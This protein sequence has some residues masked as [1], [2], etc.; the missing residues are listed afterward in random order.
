MAT[1]IGLAMFNSSTRMISVCTSRNKK[2]KCEDS[3]RILFDVRGGDIVLIK[4]DSTGKIING[5]P[6]MTDDR[7][8]I[9]LQHKF[10]SFKILK[11]IPNIWKII[12]KSSK[13]IKG[14]LTTDF[15][16]GAKNA[17][18][19]NCGTVIKD[20]FMPT[21]T[22][23]EKIPKFLM[24]FHPAQPETKSNEC[25]QW[26]SLMFCDVFY[27][28]RIGIPFGNTRLIVFHL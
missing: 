17:L 5:I 2:I 14:D 16:I 20:E 9:N 24:E 28:N 12:V 7:T 19:Y 23:P 8:R 25:L 6:L 4:V 15:W 27:G 10:P 13:E 3:N 26:N 1:F 21:E 11:T 22:K 18:F